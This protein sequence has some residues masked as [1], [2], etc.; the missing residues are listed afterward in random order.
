MLEKFQLYAQPV[1]FSPEN[2]DSPY[3]N[4]AGGG[5]APDAMR[6]MT[7]TQL[8]KGDYDGPIVDEKRQGIG[9]C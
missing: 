9:K 4:M 3:N 5:Q 8:D 1:I 7:I 6:S 2:P